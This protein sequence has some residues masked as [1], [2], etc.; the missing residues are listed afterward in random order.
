[1][2]RQ[3]LPNN[4][5]NATVSILQKKMHLNRAIVKSFLSQVSSLKLDELHHGS[6]RMQ[7][8]PSLNLL[9]M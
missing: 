3:Y 8:Q 5:E 2:I 6:W 1:M 9:L 4:N 7:G